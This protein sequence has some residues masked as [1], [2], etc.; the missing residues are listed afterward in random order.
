M[1]SNFYKS[2]NVTQKNVKNL[3]IKY[4]QKYLNLKN[5]IGGG[6][7][8][9]NDAIQDIKEICEK[10]A[11]FKHDENLKFQGIKTAEAVLDILKIYSMNGIHYGQL[12]NIE[13]D[14]IILEYFIKD[15]KDWWYKL[16]ARVRMNLTDEFPNEYGFNLKD[17]F[18]F[19]DDDD[20]YF[21]FDENGF[22]FARFLSPFMG[23]TRNNEPQQIT[24]IKVF[25][26]YDVDVEGSNYMFEI[27][28]IGDDDDNVLFS[29]SHNFNEVER[30]LFTSVDE[31]CEILKM[32]YLS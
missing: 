19:D 9:T 22:L 21:E 2:K 11:N 1:Q 5:K 23:Y 8:P 4:K 3:Y 15:T 32:L 31:F 27:Q 7:K 13:Y 14:I 24:R 25:Q 28:L 12:G 18:E 17:L 10:T 29:S 30:K 6:P 26:I 16:S 20:G